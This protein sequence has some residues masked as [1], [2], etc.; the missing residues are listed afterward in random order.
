MLVISRHAAWSEVLLPTLSNF[1]HFSLQ[2]LQLFPSEGSR[3]SA[4]DCQ[5]V[6]QLYTLPHMKLQLVFLNM[7]LTLLPVLR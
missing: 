5:A 3:V 6:M 4:F 2:P 7:V 1:L